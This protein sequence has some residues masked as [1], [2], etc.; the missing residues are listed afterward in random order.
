MNVIHEFG[1]SR[2]RIKAGLNQTSQTEVEIPSLGDIIERDLL[3]PET[4]RHETIGAA[5][6]D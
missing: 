2:F 4:D 5:H 1:V 6:L 3:Q